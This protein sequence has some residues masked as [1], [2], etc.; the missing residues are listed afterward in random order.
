MKKCCNYWKARMVLT[1]LVG[2]VVK[3]TTIKYCVECGTYL[4]Q[5]KLYDKL[6]R[7]LEIK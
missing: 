6:E 2:K 1:K 4:N 3:P 7:E 5:P